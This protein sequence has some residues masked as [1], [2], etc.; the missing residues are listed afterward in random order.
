MRRCE[1]QRFY[2]ST[3]VKL[4]NNSPEYVI[5]E[6]KA[7]YIFPVRFRFLV[8]FD[9]GMLIKSN[10]SVTYGWKTTSIKHKS[11]FHEAKNMKKFISKQ[12]RIKSVTFKI[13][14]CKNI[15]LFAFTVHSPARKGWARLGF[16]ENSYLHVFYENQFY[17]AI[18]YMTWTEP[19][20]NR[21][22]IL[23]RK[24]IS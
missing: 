3:I 24:T 12:R 4:G 5:L 22:W 9:I 18:F 17:L 23:S 8:L 16:E 14:F 2:D 10:L 11:W 20:L 1:R 13:Q 6:G 21:G 19:L 7:I 15:H